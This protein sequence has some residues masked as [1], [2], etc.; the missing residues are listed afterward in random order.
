MI[1]GRTGSVVFLNRNYWPE[2]PE[3][4]MLTDLAVD[5]VRRGWDV[6][7]IASRA[8]HGG[9]PGRLAR[10][11][12]RDGVRI[13]RVAPDTLAHRGWVGRVL[14]Y[15]QY[16]G[17]MAVILMRIPRPDIV[18]AMTD[19]PM[20]L[21]PALLLARARRARTVCWV[22][23]VF[24]HKAARLGVVQHGGVAHRAFE[25]LARFTHRQCD[26]LVS[27]GERI[28]E[29][30]REAGTPP[31]RVS[32]IPNWA[33]AAGIQPVHPESNPFRAEHGLDGAFVV[34]Y[35]GRAGFEHRFSEVMEAAWLLRDRHDV[36]FL[37]IGGGEQW[38]H[39]EADAWRLGLDKVRFMDYQPREQ[40][41]Y[42]LS[43]A[44]VSLVT[45]HPEVASFRAPSKTYGILASGRPL[46]FVGSEQSEVARIVTEHECGLVIPPNDAEALV[47][48]L[49]HLK[50]NP[51][52]AAAMGAR[53]REAAVTLYDRR[54]AT[55]RWHEVLEQVVNGSTRSRPIAAGSWDRQKPRAQRPRPV[56]IDRAPSWSE[57][58]RA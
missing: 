34:L 12:R 32:C 9:A 35:S 28:A 55:H 4:Q 7:V 58:K 52:E 6:T 45:E 42:S 27:P 23:D 39:L 8:P 13:L 29:V 16:L 43:A 25:A 38:P 30:L 1:L 54:I 22:R 48:A 44:D 57:R 5:L 26:A 17:A 18:V 11:E 10:H 46:L 53:A 41:T 21:L 33:D 47:D 15:L 37:F 19:P 40:L 49:M 3:G 56:L 36:R 50:D 51:Q 31:H 14:R 20:L 24:P 2:R